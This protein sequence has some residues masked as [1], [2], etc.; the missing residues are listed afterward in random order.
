MHA[1][2][3]VANGACAHAR[4]LGQ[5]LLRQPCRHTVASEQVPEGRALTTRILLCAG[6]SWSRRRHT[7][8]RRRRAQA[9]TALGRVACSW[10]PCTRSILLRMRGDPGTTPV[11]TTTPGRWGIKNAA[12]L[13]KPLSRRAARVSGAMRGRVAGRGEG[14][15]VAIRRRRRPRPRPRSGE[16]GRYAVP[17]GPNARAH[18]RGRG[19]GGCKQDGAASRRAPP[20]PCGWVTSRPGLERGATGLYAARRPLPAPLWARHVRAWHANAVVPPIYHAA[21]DGSKR[22]R[23]SSADATSPGPKAAMLCPSGYG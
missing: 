4:L 2:L 21:V 1:P 7:S 8:A 18:E 5:R 12:S 3:E 6:P 9:V 15:A 10:V 13:R 20:H 17:P 16:G 14:Q 19:R 22:H 23:S 11:P